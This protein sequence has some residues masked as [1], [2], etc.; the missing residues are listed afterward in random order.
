MADR[1]QHPSDSLH[2][3]IQLGRTASTDVKPGK[4]SVKTNKT[5]SVRDNA[6]A[7]VHKPNRIS[8]TYH[9]CNKPIS[10]PPDSTAYWKYS[11]S[12]CCCFCCCC[13]CCFCMA[14]FAGATAS[15]PQ[16]FITVSPAALPHHHRVTQQLP[17]TCSTTA[18]PLQT[19][20]RTRPKR[21]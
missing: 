9:N 13:C 21:H 2:A 20:S 16:S 12:W 15:Q 6:V 8:I 14:A 19:P 10:M 1:S 17:P 7:A 5:Q 11:N 18:T 3:G 4:L